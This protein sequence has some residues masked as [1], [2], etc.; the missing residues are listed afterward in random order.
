MSTKCTVMYYDN[1][2]LYH[3]CFDNQNVYLQIDN[4]QFEAS[5]DSVTLTIPLEIWESIRRCKCADL[6]L[7]GKTDEE[8][9]QQVTLE[10]E[11]RVIKYQEAHDKLKPLIALG[12]SMV[13]GDVKSSKEEQIENGVTYYQ[14]ERDK[15][16]AMK[17]K[18]QKILE[19]NK[20]VK[21]D[22]CF[23]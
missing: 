7:A 11:D 1:F 5:Q 6:S 8:L 13:Y 18:L 23:Y 17:D 16:N 4:G 3:E 22:D 15:H 20:R 2:H 19:K 9:T 14:K 12:G 21:S 10:V